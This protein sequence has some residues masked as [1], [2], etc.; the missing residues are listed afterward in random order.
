MVNEDA[1]VCTP[2][3]LPDATASFPTIRGEV[4]PDRARDCRL[5]GERDLLR[6]AFGEVTVAVN[7][8]TSDSEEKEEA[9]P[10]V[11]DE[12][13]PPSIATKAALFEVP[14]LLEFSPNRAVPALSSVDIS[15][16]GG[17][18]TTILFLSF[19]VCVASYSKEQAT[20]DN[21]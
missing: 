7:P 6:P 12:G 11:L 8:I 21:L 1:G 16:S 10:L 19:P 18:L 17:M 3:P 13:S 20:A 4:A 14:P 9:A 5:D 15:P 2:D